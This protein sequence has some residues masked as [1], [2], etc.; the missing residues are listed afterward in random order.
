MG[1]TNELRKLVKSMLLTVTK[2]VCY[3]RASDD[4]MYPHIV[5]RFKPIDLGDLHRDDIMC[6]INLWHKG[7]TAEIEDMADKVEMLFN[8]ENLPQD[9]ILPT[10]FKVDR[11]DVDDEDKTIEHRLIRVQIQNYERR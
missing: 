1:K 2:E 9:T 10:F 4:A 11:A 8:A 7:N 6:E 3:R 5:F